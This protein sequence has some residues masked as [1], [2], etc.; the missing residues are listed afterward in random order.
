MKKSV[1]A[2]SRRKARNEGGTRNDSKQNRR[3]LSSNAIGGKKSTCQL[4]LGEATK[5]N[6]ARRRSVYENGK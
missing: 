6:F 2:L 4:G 5:E 3:D 1:V